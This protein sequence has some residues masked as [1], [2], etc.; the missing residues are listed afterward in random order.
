MGILWIGLGHY[1][2]TTGRLAEHG[3][4]WWII[5]EKHLVHGLFS[6]GASPNVSYFDMRCTQVVEGLV[7]SFPATVCRILFHDFH[8]F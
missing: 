3:Q 2:L 7:D 6:R 8:E 5:G 1:I 4:A